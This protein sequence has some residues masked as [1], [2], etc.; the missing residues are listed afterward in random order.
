MVLNSPIALS[1]D[2]SLAMKLKNEELKQTAESSVGTLRIVQT[3]SR[4]LGFGEDTAVAILFENKN[5][6]G[7][8]RGNITDAI[9]Q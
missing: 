1:E 7:N 2:T 3:N 4:S 9:F 8:C 6:G 5:Y